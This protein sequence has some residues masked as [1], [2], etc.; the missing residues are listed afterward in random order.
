M[1]GGS[2]RKRG[3]GIAAI[4]VNCSSGAGK[5][6]LLGALARRGEER[7]GEPRQGYLCGDNQ[8]GHMSPLSLPIAQAHVAHSLGGGGTDPLVATMSTMHPG[9]GNAATASAPGG[10]ARKGSVVDWGMGNNDGDELDSSS[11]N[12]A[13]GKEGTPLKRKE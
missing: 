8:C 11:G 10:G 12:A 13:G 4:A 2:L 7:Q 5:R 9:T 1:E 3:W 6:H